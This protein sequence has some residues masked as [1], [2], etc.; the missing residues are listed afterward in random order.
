DYDF[1]SSAMLVT[2]PGGNEILVAGQKSGVV[3]GLDPDQKGRI[4]WQTRVGQGGRN[5][6]VQWGMASD[7][8][9]VFAAVSDLAGVLNS[10]GVVGGASFDAAKGGGW[11]ALRP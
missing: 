11:T 7:G 3:Y 5:G 1:G 6:G 8:Q 9:A 10:T 2:L 4:L